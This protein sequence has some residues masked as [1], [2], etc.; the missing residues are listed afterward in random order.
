MPG[1]LGA[2]RP[3]VVT[4]VDPEV[5]T[6]EIDD[7]AIAR[8]L[9]IGEAARLEDSAAADAV[10]MR[11]LME[12]ARLAYSRITH[13]GHDLAVPLA[14]LLGGGPEQP[15]LRIAPNE[16]AQAPLDSSLDPSPHLPRPNH[17]A[18]LDGRLET[19]HRHS[20]HRSDLD[21][22]VHETAGL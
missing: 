5:G 13:H 4:I 21:E 11:Q 10:G 18:D 3:Q 19:S 8:G 7:R 6:Q 17:L 14:D 15:H 2:D 22:A 12:K 16:L 20:A 9:P 1:D